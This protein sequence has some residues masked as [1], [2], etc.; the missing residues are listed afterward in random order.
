V[1]NLPLHLS[2]EQLQQLQEVV[3]AARQ[4]GYKD[5]LVGFLMVLFTLQQMNF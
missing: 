5:G 2:E 3:D 1:P 4:G